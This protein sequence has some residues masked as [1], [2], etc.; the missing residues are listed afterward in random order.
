[1]EALRTLFPASDFT[2]LAAILALP[3]LGALVNGLFGKRLGKEGVRLMA[4]AA[5]GGSFLASVLT[6][7]LLPAEGKLTWTAW[8]W[9]SI[10]G[11]MGQSIPI[12][13]AFSVDAL[14][15]TMMLVITGVGFLIHLYS[16]EYMKN[17]PGFHRF[18]AYLNL[19][20]FAMLTLVMGDN[21]AMLF[22]GWEG[23]GLCSYLLIGFWYGEDKNAAAGKKAFIVNRIG[24]FGLLVAM[25]LI[26]YYVGTLRFDGIQ[27][28]ASSLLQNV[29][30]WPIGN[31][32]SGTLP[33][34]LHFLLPEQPVTIL[35]ATAVGL[36]VFLGCAGKSAQIPLYIW[37]PDA[38]AGPTP[39][40]A[41]I[42][43]ATMVTAGVYLVARLSAVF[44][45]SPAALAVV[46]VTGAL[47]ALLAATI[48][49]FQNDLKKVLAYSTVSQL[50]Y[51]FIGV[52][53]GAFAAGFFHVFTHAFFKACLFLGAGSVI[54]AIHVR[55]HDTDR[56]QDMGNMGGLK[57]Y[58]PITRWTYL[59][60]CFAIAGLPILG[61]GFWSKDEILW[62]AFTVDIMAVSAP[63]VSQW[64]WPSWLGR[65]IYW[66]GVT[67]AVFT[68]FYMFR[69]YFRTF[70]GE[71]RGWKIDPTWKDPGH[72]H[73][74]DD[75]GHDDHHE[76]HGEITGPV[77]HESPL[78]MTIPLMVLAAFSIGA[79]FL[80]AEPI[81]V[82]PLAHKLEPVFAL[83]SRAIRQREGTEGLLFPMM[84]PGIAAFLAGTVGAMVVYQNR[85]GEPERRFA[86]MFP[87][88]HRLIY[89]KWRIDELY[90]ATVVGMVD[91]LADI[92]TIADKWIVDGILAKF[93]AALVGFFGTVLRAFQTGRV[94]VY[95]A[96]MVLGL[97]GVGWF[98]V[99]PHADATVNDEALRR[100]GEVKL[101]A[102]PGL[103]YSY[104]WDTPGVS[105]TTFAKTTEHTVK[106]DPGETK[107]VTLRV[108]NAWGSESSETFTLTRP[109]GGRRGATEPG[110]LPAPQ[111]PT[112]PTGTIPAE[113]IPDLIQPKGLQ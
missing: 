45:L 101:S 3:A 62:K 94:Q 89:D 37:L 100:S 9:I 35:A 95:A 19:F 85:R 18:F 97:V 113:R 42:H 31:M 50:G 84:L 73:G 93:T 77:P 36:M 60:A 41:L 111:P 58:M 44:V 27:S 29:K 104:R 107:D 10:Q 78:P 69:S 30:I 99:K 48:G 49:L 67:G 39:V 51:M 26:V 1:M 102:A 110:A 80:V 88:L 2:L 74:H 25:A 98:M 5:L 11:R 55:I 91:A 105:E 20:C 28:G 108:R 96:A 70:H 81:H 56:S 17:D 65:A 21:L 22:V 64:M 43:A 6:Y 32:S 90:D 13:V 72:G 76:E 15:G 87:R 75:H 112:L 12:D 86:T 34:F 24:D 46:A 83:S 52:G 106:L 4:L 61:S 47:T 8:R 63:G 109:A 103:G 40:S 7:L 33:G 23:V 53:V 82:A 38:M 79:G 57:A 71:F 92:F 16:S 59:I 54:H 68:S 14:S 66:A